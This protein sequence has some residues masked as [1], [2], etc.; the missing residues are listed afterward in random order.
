MND[1]KPATLALPTNAQFL[2]AADMHVLVRA[3]YWAYLRGDTGI[4]SYIPYAVETFARNATYLGIA[5]GSGLSWRDVGWNLSDQI[6]MSYAPSTGIIEW[7]RENHPRVLKN[8]KF[9]KSAYK[10][11]WLKSM[12]D[13]FNRG[14]VLVDGKFWP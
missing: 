13:G 12:M 9:S 6:R 7:L 14:Q 2:L 3:I 1:I 5:T 4:S 8:R 10:I 11:A